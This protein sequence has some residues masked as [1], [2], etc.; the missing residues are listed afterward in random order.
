MLGPIPAHMSVHKCLWRLMIYPCFH[1]PD[2]LQV[3][4]LADSQK[5]P[6]G[7]GILG[8]VVPNFPSMIQT[9]LMWLVILE[10]KSTTEIKK[11]KKASAFR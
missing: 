1:F 6:D 10:T 3:S 2:F 7:K 9:Y 4:L 8:N 11:K 5:K